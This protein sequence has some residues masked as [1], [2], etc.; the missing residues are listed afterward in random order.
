MEKLHPP[1]SHLPSSNSENAQGFSVLALSSRAIP[2][3]TGRYLPRGAWKLPCSTGA[4]FEV[5]DAAMVTRNPIDKVGPVARTE[6][7]K[8]VGRMVKKEGPRAARACI[9][10]SQ[11][12]PSSPH[13]LCPAPSFSPPQ[14]P[15]HGSVP[16][17]PHQ[18]SCCK[19][20]RPQSWS[21]PGPE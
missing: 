14:P 5:P 8:H 12:S 11:P 18:L 2:Q 1:V 13:L 6:E 21:S 3:S 4:E 20:P 19:V 7:R 9:P 16:A 15:S 17:P 10:S